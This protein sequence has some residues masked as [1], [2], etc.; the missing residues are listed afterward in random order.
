L[1][2]LQPLPGTRL[3]D[4]MESEGRLL[5]RNFPEDWQIF[6]DNFVMGVN[7]K[8]NHMSTRQLQE[9]VKEIGS[10]FYSPLRMAGRLVRILYHTRSLSIALLVLLNSINSR[11]AYVNF[12]LAGRKGTFLGWKERVSRLMGKR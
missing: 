7:Y 5:I 4:R 12:D 6:T 9:T 11:K 10:A 8:L 2:I 3:Y 1:Q